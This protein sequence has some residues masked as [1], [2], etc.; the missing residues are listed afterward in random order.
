[1]A[2]G[3]HPARIQIDP[4]D[5]QTAAK[6][7][8]SW[9]GGHLFREP[10]RFPTLTSQDLFGDNKP[11]EIDFGCGHGLL[12]CNRASQDP[13]SNL[14]GI[15]ASLK[16]LYCAI[17]DAVELRLDNIKFIHADYNVMLPLLRPGTV[18]TAYYLFPNPPENYYMERANAKRRL[19]L[20]SIY[21]ALIPGGRFYFA[22][23]DVQYFKC[24][25]FILRNGLQYKMF[26]SE[27][28]DSGI[29]TCYRQR[30]DEQGRPLRSIVV[31]KH[32]AENI[33]A[34]TPS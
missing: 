6:Y 20:Q 14:L 34:R 23:D 31:E 29:S 33:S 25:H 12:A 1:M 21:D 24:I 30:W 27:D 32:H 3:R 5:E 17:R 16:P 10:H 11:L 19:F 2:R 26:E 28:L 9:Y 13:D 22:T 15:D 18:S 7:F 4:P 8:H